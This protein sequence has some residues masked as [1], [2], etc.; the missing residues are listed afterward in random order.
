M[1]GLTDFLA[2]WHSDSPTIEAHSS[3]STGTPKRIELLKSDMAASA[4]ATIA[5]FGLTAESVLALPLSIDYIAGKMMVVRAVIAGCR[6][7]QVPVSNVIVLP[8]EPALVDLLAVVPTQLPSL[9]ATPEYAARIGIL[10]IGGGAPAQD[11]CDRLIE[12]GYNI[13]LSYGMTETC[14]HV[15]LARA[16]DPRRIYHA[17]P[18]ITFDT[19]TRGCLRIVAPAFSFGVLQ[20]NDIVELIDSQS[21]IYRGRADSIINSGGLK[22]V[23]EEIE[24][25]CAPLLPGRAFYVVGRPH[26][27]WGQA[28][29]LV[30]EGRPDEAAAIMDRLRRGIADHRMLPKLIETVATLPRTASG[31]PRRI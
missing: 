27:Q 1:A 2:Q 13:V 3:G 10:L 14:S 19:D 28:A 26:R 31:K 9:L 30:I 6:L 23:A 18:G 4:R 8:D 24:A 22:L 5:A 16:D 29:C 21:F 7:L 11:M 17:L 12:V 20:T 15:A 25:L